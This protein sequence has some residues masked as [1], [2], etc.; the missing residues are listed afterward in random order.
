V[1]QGRR[2]EREALERLLG[3]VRGEQSRVLVVSGEPGMG[4]TAPVESAIGSAS[5][6]RVMRARSPACM[7]GGQHA[8]FTA[9]QRTGRYR[10]DSLVRSGY[11]LVNVSETRHDRRGWEH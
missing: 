7:T 1:L 9:V 3:A 4:R 11:G 10:A 5:G 8:Q 2:V 6:F